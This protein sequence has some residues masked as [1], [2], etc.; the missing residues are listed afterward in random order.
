MSGRLLMH[1]VAA[2]DVQQLP[3]HPPRL[4]RCQEDD[5]VS[6]IVWLP[7]APKWR[8]RCDVLLGFPVQVAGLNSTRR[9]DVNRYPVYLPLSAP[10]DSP[11]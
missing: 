8:L 2:S 9:H 1:P 10:R 11:V 5:H 3:C 7:D 4:R 6:D